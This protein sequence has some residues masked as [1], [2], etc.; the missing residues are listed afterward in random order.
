MT[1][2]DISQDILNMQSSAKIGQMLKYPDQK[3][4]LTKILKRPA[5]QKETNHVETDATKRTTTAKC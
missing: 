4:N 5:Q 1:P 2:Y 3:R